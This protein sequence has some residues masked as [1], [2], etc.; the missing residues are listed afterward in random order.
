NNRKHD[1]IPETLTLSLLVR[2]NQILAKSL[3]R[4]SDSAKTDLN[5]V[6]MGNFVSKKGCCQSLIASTRLSQERA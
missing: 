1:S 2:N 3:L 4:S 5:H 6:G